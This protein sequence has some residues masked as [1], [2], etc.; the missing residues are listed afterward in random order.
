[1]NWLVPPWMLAMKS[2]MGNDPPRSK[3]IEM[4]SDVDAIPDI[5]VARLRHIDQFGVEDL[6]GDSHFG[7]PPFSTFYAPGWVGF[8]C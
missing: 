1:M 3:N 6:I 7:R 4:L 2:P 8:R 5:D